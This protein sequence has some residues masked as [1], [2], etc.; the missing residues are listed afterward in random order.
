MKGIGVIALLLVGLWEF[1]YA[2][3]YHV[4]INGNDATGD[5]SSGKPW[6]TI[7]YAL[8]KIPANQGH[9]LQ[10]SSGTFIESAF[11]NVPV[12][13]NIQGA[14]IDATIIRAASNLYYPQ[15]AYGNKTHYLVNLSNG[16]QSTKQTIKGFTIDGSGKQVYGGLIVY[17]RN[18]VIL[19]S[20]SVRDMYYCGIRLQ[21]T[22]DSRMTKCTIRNSS[23]GSSSYAM[24]AFLIGDVERVEIDNNL[25]DENFAYGIK[26]DGGQKM[27]NTKFHH[28][29]ITVNPVGAWKTNTGASAPNMAFELW[30]GDLRNV[31]IYENNMDNV[32]SIVTKNVSRST[33]TQTVRVY[34]NVFDHTKRANGRGYGIELSISDVE[35][36]HNFFLGGTGGI[37][38]W[39]E[40]QNGTVQNWKIHHNVFYRVAAGYPTGLVT[41][42]RGGLNNVHIYNN[43]IEHSGR[44]SMHLVEI[45]NGGVG[46]NL[47]VENNLVINNFTELLYNEAPKLLNTKNNARYQNAI[48]RNNFTD[49]VSVLA[50]A[51]VTLTNNLTGN[52][53]IT[54]SGERPDPYY[55]PKAGS[56][57]IDKGVMISGVSY[58]GS[59]PDIGAFEYGQPQTT[60]TNQRPQGSIA[61]PSNNSTFA[62]GTPIEIRAN[63][64]DP[65]GSVTKV[66]FFAGNTKLGEDT[67]A[68]YTFQWSNAP[69]GTHD[70]TVR[71]TDNANATTTSAIVKITVVG[72]TNQAPT[73]NITSPATNAEFPEGTT[74]TFRVNATDSDGTIVKVEYFN[75]SQKIGE[76]TSAPFTFNWTNAPVGDNRINAKAT[77]DKGATANSPTIRVVVLAD[78]NEAPV[79]ALSAPA[80]NSTHMEGSPITLRA[81]ATDK[82]GTI[83]KVEFYQGTNKLGED[84]TEPYSLSWDNARVGSY[85]IIARATD[86][87]DAVGVSAPLSI[88]VQAPSN[89]LPTVNLTS[90]S[91]NATLNAGNISL[92]ATASD[93]DGAVTKVEFFNGSTKLGEDLSSPY[94]FTWTGVRA[95][96]YTLTA[97]ATDNRSGVTTSTPVTITVVEPNKAPTVAITSPANNAS[98]SQ[99]ATVNIQ[100]TASDSDGA[101]SK[102]EFFNGS[103]KLGEDLSSPYSFAWTN[104]PAGS[105]TIT[106]RATDNKSATTT[107][108]AITINVSAD[109]KLP[110][111]QLTAPQQN[112]RFESG[113]TITLSASASDSDGS[114]TKVAF[115]NGSTL[116]G[117][118][119]SSPYSYVWRNVQPGT[120]TLTAKATDNRSG[121][122]TSNAVTITV[123]NANKEPVVQ[124]RKP[125]NNAVFTA[126]EPVSIEATASDSDGQITKV[127]F[128]RGNVRLGEDT[129][130]PYAIEWSNPLPGKYT[131]SVRATDNSGA[132]ASASVNIEVKEAIFEPVARAGQD[133]S[134]ELPQNTITLIGNGESD[135]GD[136]VEYKWEQIEGP[137]GAEIQVGPDGEAVVTN[138][139][140]GVYRFQ[141]TV[142]D[143]K[144]QTAT[145]VI[146]VRVYPAPLSTVNLPRFFTPNGDGENETW[147]W[148]N[149]ELFRGSRLVIFNRHGQKVY[150]VTSYDNSWD[151]TVNGEPLQEDAYYYV[152]TGNQG[153]L[154]GAV[155]IIR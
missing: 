126:G 78:A 86:D 77:D 65:D 15:S 127:E 87:K 141:F 52:P 150:E 66:E 145:D 9:T 27:W 36:D 67:S 41:F 92:T 40:G 50:L 55:R 101:I 59:A 130:S 71:V 122:T 109:N 38:H 95:G 62:L 98:F 45:D 1:S 102:V 113:A 82:D 103:T 47:R 10:I 99:G 142:I 17:N 139:T 121:V 51:G 105:H 75:R 24:G 63:A 140:E 129:S 115:Y 107:S 106:A 149:T 123:A 81:T 153:E 28:N 111:V 22:N 76:V 39:G 119:T 138:L 34:N 43:T 16:S 79:V 147:E 124:I 91:N 35:V 29:T 53:Q 152:I 64:A 42:V 125:A 134:I 2:A 73:I 7:G 60:P 136:I 132:T 83:K 31:E 69:A 5:G 94:T 97:R 21:K 6:R 133:V 56:P 33:G 137:Q 11:L 148:S 96:T 155:R 13:V 58:S 18:N 143:V 30:D 154:T 48:V 93:P 44:G 108:Q 23:W 84:T 54:A 144:N 116:L 20:I 146:T 100:V 117:E 114:I 128:F 37:V 131:L 112:A 110:L 104:V 8:S 12:G 89:Q 61:S 72:A 120:Y 3:T 70:L 80:N 90:P 85:T 68:P 46:Q 151:G 118:D 32:L 74:I 26:L 57:L 14:G 25:V 135:N 19:E 88:H 4:S 49:R